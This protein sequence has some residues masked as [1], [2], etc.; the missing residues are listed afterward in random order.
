MTCRARLFAPAGLLFALCLATATQAAV[1][2]FAAMTGSWSGAG[3]L[4]TAE[5]N[6]ERLRCRASYGVGGSGTDLQ[7]R[8][9]CASPSYNFELGS[10]LA[11]QGGRISGSWSEASHNA[12]GSIVGRASGDRIE[13]A[14]NG[15]NFAANL[16]I[17]TRGD[18][19]IV[20]IRS[21]GTDITGVTLT[22]KR[23]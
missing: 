17:V 6:A 13:A 8:I 18:Q 5:G 1:S 4:S 21:R 9:K 14:A 11:Y 12:N 10:D 20:S 3:T 2:P 16:S 19:Q 22:L 7:L 15:Q 23:R